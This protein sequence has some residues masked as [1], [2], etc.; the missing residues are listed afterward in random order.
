MTSMD[1]KIKCAVF[2]LDGTLINTI[3][4]LGN[5]CNYVIQKHGFDAHWSENDYKRFVGNGMRLLVDRAFRHTLNEETLTKYLHEFKAY[6]AETYLD[7]TFPYDGIKEQLALLKQK[8]IKL[9]V[10]TNKAEE[11]AVYIL[12]QLF[13][14]DTFDVIVGQRDNLP[15]KPHPQGVFLALS[16][17]GCTPEEAIYFGDSNVDIQTAKN[18]HIRAIGVTWGFRSK[19]ELEAEG[20]DL[21]IDR[22]DQITTLI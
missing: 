6:Y 5:A 2:D 18:A 9:A 21:L 7:N 11:A 19:E 8:G 12:E 10:V 22:P 17:V 20:A 3:T 1:N 13:D 15:T 14:K 16:Q 4:D